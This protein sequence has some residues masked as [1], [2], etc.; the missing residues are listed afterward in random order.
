[1][2]R[3]DNVSATQGRLVVGEPGTTL[4]GKNASGGGGRWYEFRNKVQN[5]TQLRTL[6]KAEDEKNEKLQAELASRKRMREE[7]YA[8]RKF[9]KRVR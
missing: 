5:E 9:V 3:P 4:G 2:P 6:K 1:M 7:I 8:P